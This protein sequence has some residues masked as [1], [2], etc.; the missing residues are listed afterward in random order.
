MVSCFPSRFLHIPIDWRLRVAQRRSSPPATSGERSRSWS[1]CRTWRGT[2][3]LGAGMSNAWGSKV[4]STHPREYTNYPPP[5]W[6]G[7]NRQANGR[8]AYVQFMCKSQQKWNRATHEKPMPEMQAKKIIGA[9]IWQ[10]KNWAGRGNTSVFSLTCFCHPEPNLSYTKFI[11]DSYGWTVI[12]WLAV[13]PPL[14]K[15]WVRQ[16]GW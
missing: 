14:W 3:K 10:T 15:I 2:G 8:M 16:L 7:Y 5:W 11:V 13:G 1:V 4:P 6:L 12:V 9:D